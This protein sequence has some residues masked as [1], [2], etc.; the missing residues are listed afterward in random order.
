MGGSY[1]SR[2]V[3][4]CIAVAFRIDGTAGRLN[5]TNA[6]R[7]DQTKALGVTAPAG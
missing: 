2:K 1:T 7:T 5:A 4:S 6:M 3:E